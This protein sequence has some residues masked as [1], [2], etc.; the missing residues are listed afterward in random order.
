MAMQ[1]RRV[2]DI[3]RADMRMLDVP[4][5]CRPRDDLA[6]SLQHRGVDMSGSAI[7]R[8]ESLALAGMAAGAIAAP[9]LAAA[10]KV[11]F[12]TKVDFKDPKW[13]R[14]TFARMDGDLDPAKEKLGWL[15]GTAYGVRDNEKVRPL[16]AVEGFSLV[17][18]KRLPDGNWRRMLREIV[19]YRDLETGKILET[20]RNPYTNE[21]VRVVPIA[22]DP[23]NYTIADT[24]GA[25]PSYG[26]LQTVQVAPKPYLLDWSDGPDG[27]L[28][29]RT[30][31]DMIYPSALQP[32][33]WP[34]ESA[35]S[36]NRVS[37]HFIFTVKRKDVENPAM[38]HVPA[39][40]AW[41]R[42]T[43]WLPWM[44]MGQAP[45]NISYFTNF[46]TLHSLADL[47]ADLVAAARAKDEKWLHAPTEDYG[48]SLSSLENY[49]REQTPAPVPAGWTPPQPP[50]PMKMPPMPPKAG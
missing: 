18:I 50:P 27:T 43:P 22:N 38:T 24:V 23:F 48:P 19:F 12:V 8:R 25:P 13:N 11:D 29:C 44:L 40:G 1:G 41:S 39:I 32:D 16:F 7:T 31:I 6:Y 10:P 30:G 9:A 45:G 20:W 3:H 36:M 33:K 49:A 4:N 5:G 47:P 46:A 21:D 17:R 42:I 15:K 35:G 34:R 2:G 26:G 28:I 37:E 14:D